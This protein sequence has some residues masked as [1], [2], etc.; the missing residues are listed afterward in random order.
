M[1]SIPEMSAN[2]Y[3]KKTA[4]WMLKL[5]K[6]NILKLLTGKIISGKF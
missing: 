4:P 6:I 5:L 2:C 1:G 3:F